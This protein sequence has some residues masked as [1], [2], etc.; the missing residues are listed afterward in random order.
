MNRKAILAGSVEN[1][2]KRTSK[3]LLV[4]GKQPEQCA[5]RSYRLKW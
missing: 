5:C 3:L 1:D 2:P 4:V